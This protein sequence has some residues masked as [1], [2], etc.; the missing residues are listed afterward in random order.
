[1]GSE[2]PL[3]T[4]GNIVDKVKS[5]PKTGKD[6]FVDMESWELYEDFIDL[7][8][9]LNGHLGSGI[10]SME[11]IKDTGNYKSSDRGFSSIDKDAIKTLSKYA[12]PDLKFSKSEETLVTEQENIFEEY[13]QSI[14]IDEPFFEADLESELGVDYETPPPEFDYFNF[15]SVLETFESDLE[16]QSPH[17]VLHVHHEN[18]CYQ[19]TA[20][21][22][23]LIDDEEGESSDSSVDL[24]PHIGKIIQFKNSKFTPPTE[25]FL[26]ISEVIIEKFI[27]EVY[28]YHKYGCS[29]CNG[30]FENLYQLIRHYEKENFL[31]Q[32][33]FKCV[34]R[35]CPFHS[36]G[37]RKKLDVR[38]HIIAEHYNNK[39]RNISDFHGDEIDFMK[40]LLYF[41]KE[42][43]KAFYRNDT[44]KRHEKHVHRR[45]RSRRKP[46]V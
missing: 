44:L 43:E 34:I 46:R 28:T 33:K 9:K 16:D 20:T 36:I 29:H 35:N 39:T 5:N 1:M 38:R 10:S 18:D 30:E 8:M 17:D 19:G 2:F 37:F 31:D 14:I 21:I 12:I 22:E 25:E 32:L 24:V 23:E 15:D 3:G 40:R 7:E 45:L 41:C 27:D 11:V 4:F 6:F 42:C 13:H 26:K